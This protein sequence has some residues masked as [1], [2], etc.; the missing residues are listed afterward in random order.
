MHNLVAPHFPLTEP[1]LKIV[2]TF[3]GV[4]G[5]CFA[6]ACNGSFV[7]DTADASLQPTPTNART[8][9]PDLR[10]TF[11]DGTPGFLRL[12][13][14][15]DRQD[16]RHWFTLIAERQA[17][18][19]PLPREIN[20]CA[21][22][23]RY[24]YREAMR[25]H[26]AIWATTMDLGELPA[27][28]DIAKYQ[29]PYTPLGPRIFRVKQGEFAQADLSDGTFAEFADVRTLVTDN[30]HAVGRDVHRAQPGD[31]IFFRQ[32]EQ[33]SPFH[34]MIFVGR[35][36]FGSGDDWVVYHT[37]PSGSRPGEMRRVQL[38]SLLHHPDPRWRPTAGN[39]NFL[40]VY[41]W[42][43]LREAN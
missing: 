6:A 17:F 33:R 16:F 19:N 32:F 35:S 22:L 15:T 5:L 18:L 3:A 9:I 41:R 13:S 40:G 14:L 23:L 25:R 27:V 21:A 2:L 4:A 7:P 30:A 43:I 39:P 36:S 26:D 31:L 29:Y 34:S 1:G 37:G 38:Q 8:A 42:N 28:S 20:D 11:G 10:D 12:D 24:S